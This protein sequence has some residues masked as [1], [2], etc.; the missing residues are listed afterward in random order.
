MK[1]KS[2]LYGHLVD[3]I[4]V[5][6][7]TLLLCPFVVSTSFQKKQQHWIVIKN[8]KHL[9]QQKNCNPREADLGSNCSMEK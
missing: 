1:Y 7:V 3:N 8:K 6:H 4:Q 5:L 9:C 2:T